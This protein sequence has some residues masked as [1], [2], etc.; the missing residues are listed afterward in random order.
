MKIAHRRKNAAMVV[1]LSFI[2][3]HVLKIAFRSVLVL[4]IIV[5]NFKI[6][7]RLF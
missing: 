2:V 6:V 1:E 3:L 5:L 7:M 4:S